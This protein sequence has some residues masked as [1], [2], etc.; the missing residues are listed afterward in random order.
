MTV[1]PNLSQLTMLLLVSAFASASQANGQTAAT[2]L[3]ISGACASLTM[4]GWARASGPIIYLMAV[5][6][7]ED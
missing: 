3:K 4:P 7:T 2:P 1:C 6:L 5:V